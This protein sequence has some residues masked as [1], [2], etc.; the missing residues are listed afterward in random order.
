M[1]FLPKVMKPVPVTHVPAVAPKPV[2]N[3]A[4]SVWLGLALSLTGAWEGMNTHAYHDSIGVVTICY[5]VTNV[6][7]PVKMGDTATPAECKD[8]LAKDLPRYDAMVHKCI[9]KVDSFPP[10]RHAALVSFTYNVGQGNLCKSS[11]ARKLNAGDVKGGCDA[12]LLYDKAGGKVLKGLHNRR[13]NE[14]QWCLRS[15]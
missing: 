8:W 1:W 7:R 3:T 9:P 13:V 2:A 12:L 15:D 11:V 14:H 10:H 6:D 4:A 5:G